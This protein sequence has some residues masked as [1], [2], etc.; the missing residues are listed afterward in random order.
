M[1]R[2][3][4]I[5]SVCYGSTGNICKNL[6]KMAEKEGHECCIAYGRGEAPEG[7]NCKRI[8]SS[9][10]VY[11]HAF[12][13]RINDMSG[14]GSVYVTRKFVGW[15]EEYKPDIIHMHNLHGYY[16]NME[17]LFQYLKQRPEIKKIWTLHDCWSFTGHCPH[18]QF[19]KCYQWIYGCKSCSR[20]NEYPKSLLDKCERNYYKKKKAFLN[21]DNM[22]IVTPSKWLKQMVEQSYLNEYRVV[23]VYNGINTKIFR[24]TTSSILEKNHIQDKKIILGVASVWDYKKGLDFFI[25]L[26]R[27]IADDYKIVLIGLNKEQI[28]QMPPRI[29]GIERTE[30]VKELVE[31]YSSASVFLNPSLEDTYP[32]VNLEAQAC[33]RY[34]LTFDTGGMKETIKYS[35]GR[36][37]NSIDDVLTFL[38]EK[39][40]PKV[41]T[42]D[43]TQYNLESCFKEYVK[44]YNED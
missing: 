41:N 40:V 15:L 32:T 9:L 39:S 11:A 19:E 42:E 34:I 1:A 22:T 14:F 17:L 33:G 6:Y 44:M 27:Y 28:K 35:N 25:E 10:D 26:S 30:N 43:K 2:I 3:V 31:W 20:T 29:M 7:F 21:V 8:G 18:F 13:A 37:V 38:K 5:N 16:L 12:L 4:F 24:N 36:I 23:V